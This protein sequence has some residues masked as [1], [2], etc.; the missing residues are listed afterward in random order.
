MSGLTSLPRRAASVAVVCVGLALSATAAQAN[1]IAPKPGQLF[2]V[3]AAPIQ[4]SQAFK[5]PNRGEAP[6]SAGGATR[7]QTCLKDITKFKSLIP[8]KLPGLTTNA[9]PTFYWHLPEGPATKANFLLLANKDQD[10]VYETTVD[11]PA[12][13]GVMSFTLPKDAPALAPNQQ[14]HWFLVAQC[15]QK[16]LS[17]NPSVEGWIER[18]E[19][20][21][22]LM[23]QIET[24]DLATRATLLANN[25]IWY[26]ALA[27]SAQLRTQQADSKE[28][29]AAWAK[30]LQSVGLNDLVQAP[31]LSARLSQE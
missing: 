17:A 20:E 26:D 5:A 1:A 28:A 13:A 14:Y 9:R 4:L 25:G 6:P 21:P 11:L 16:N 10:V 29:K 22:G 7:G 15:N 24:A 2:P 23:Q 18:V 19:L 27:A 8:G 3:Q 30:L 31:V 12:K